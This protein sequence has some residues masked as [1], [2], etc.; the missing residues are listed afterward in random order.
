MARKALPDVEVKRSRRR[1]KT[2]A[3]Y[4][5]QGRVVVMI[6]DQFT[7]AEEREWVDRMLARLDDRNERDG[8]TSDAA[9]ESRA[10][11]LASRHLS[12]FHLPLHLRSVRWVDNQRNRW[13]SCTPEDGT[14]R[15]SRRIIMMP[16][17]VIDYV[18]M[19]EL[20]HLVH[21]DHS[22]AFWKLVS[23]YPK[24][25]RAKGYLEAVADIEQTRETLG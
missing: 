6:P 3:A 21:P 17:W 4:E 18:L 13:G 11:R 8:R 9:L 16:S 1:K 10:V 23:R 19:H 2:V 25:E 22:P 12:E 24:A 5:D 14:I 20:A 15:I 7:P